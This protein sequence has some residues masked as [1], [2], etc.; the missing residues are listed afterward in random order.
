MLCY[1]VLGTL[2]VR[3][4][5]RPKTRRNKKIEAMGS[6][7]RVEPHLDEGLQACRWY[8]GGSGCLNM[9]REQVEI[10]HVLPIDRISPDPD[11]PR[12][13]FDEEEEQ[14]LA[15]SIRR[16]D[17]LQPIMVRPVKHP[18]YDYL[19]VHGERRFRAHRRLGLQAIRAIVRDIGEHEAR[20]LQLLENVQRRDL[21]DIELAWEFNKRIEKGHTHEQ[22]SKIIGKTKSYVTQRLSLLRLSKESQERMLRGDLKFSKARLLLS[23]KDPEDRDRISKKISKD[24]T[25]KQVLGLI[26][27]NTA[28]RMVTRVTSRNPR[29]SDL[30]IIQN[31]AVR[32]TIIREDGTLRETVPY[33]ELIRAYI[34]DIKILR[35]R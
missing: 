10:I 31:L 23:I 20:D 16:H 19:I 30:I 8:R 1:V 2:S 3:E 17:L 34:A 9:T 6:L 11:Q 27:E 26:K 5:N 7:A 25:V 24:M 4:N 32:K 29:I 12:K 13:F 28:R 14:R 18:S 15:E 22:I 33:R 35:G 21:S